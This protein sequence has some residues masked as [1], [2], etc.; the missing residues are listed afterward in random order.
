MARFELP[1]KLRASD[2]SPAHL[3]SC[4]ACQQMEARQSVH[5][6][7]LLSVTRP[8]GRL[9]HPMKQQRMDGGYRLAVI[10]SKIIA[11]PFILV[12]VRR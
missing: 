6:L 7:F 5:L 1:Q 8:C 11:L 2:L 4:P 10:S 9:P 12:R 3:A